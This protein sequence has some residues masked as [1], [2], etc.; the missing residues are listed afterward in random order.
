MQCCLKPQ[1]F[2]CPRKHSW[3]NIAQIKTLCSV[4]W[5]AP[6]TIVQEKILYNV[7]LIPLGQHYTGKNPIQCCPW[8]S[9]QQCTGKN[10]IQYCL[11]T[12]GTLHR[13]K[14]YTLL[15]LLSWDNIAQE[16]LYAMLS[17]RLQTTLHRKKSRQCCLKNIWSFIMKISFLYYGN[18]STNQLNTEKQLGILTSNWSNF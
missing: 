16:K 12:L 17:Q 6:N 2:P 3:D 5:E 15:S 4:F 18:H 8:G 10:P 7:V 1:G 14:P 11:N 13:L 9:R